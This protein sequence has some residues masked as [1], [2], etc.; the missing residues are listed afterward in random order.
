MGE[1]GIGAEARERERGEVGSNSQ[2]GDRNPTLENGQSDARACERVITA[3]EAAKLMSITASHGDVVASNT[4]VLGVDECSEKG[5]GISADGQ[6]LAGAGGRG[7]TSE[8]RGKD[9]GA[10]TVEEGQS[11]VGRGAEENREDVEAQRLGR[12]GGVKAE[13]SRGLSSSIQPSNK[14]GGKK[15]VANKKINRSVA[16]GDTKSRSIATYF[17]KMA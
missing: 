5:S 12:V 9:D 7:N 6:A 17:T 13:G 8:E 15:V 16:N 2:A 4:A 10:E 1:G 3:G 11:E 14:K